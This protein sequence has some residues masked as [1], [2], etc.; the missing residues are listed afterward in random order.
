MRP[1]LIKPGFFDDEQLCQ[2]PMGARL[3][4]AGLLCL[5]DR[6]GRLLD[7]PR[8]ISADV[9]PHDLGIDSEVVSWLDL[10]AVGQWIKRYQADGKKCIVINSFKV[11]Q[12][13]HPDEKRSILPPV[14]G[15]CDTVQRGE[16]GKPDENLIGFSLEPDEI[17]KRDNAESRSETETET[18]AETHTPDA[19]VSPSREK[20]DPDEFQR[21]TAAIWEEHPADVRGSPLEN[22]RYASD[23]IAS[24]VHPAQAL[25]VAESNHRK[26]VAIYLAKGYNHSLKTWWASGKWLMDPG[27]P[28][29]SRTSAKPLTR[30]QRI[31][32]GDAN[33][34]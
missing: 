32:R 8:R 5:A 18:E 26:W 27:E 19:R 12:K 23:S 16:S 25:Q 9:F 29:L 2:L 34:H 22:A 1:R 24:A 20:V 10:L 31:A 21:V 3:L 30:L 33:V 11:H 13:I 6:E 15:S 17:P 14:P 28:P 7:I 4:F